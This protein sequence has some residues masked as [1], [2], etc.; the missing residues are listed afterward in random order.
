M[1]QEL[2]YNS[3]LTLILNGNMKGKVW[4][5]GNNDYDR[6]GSSDL[7]NVDFPS[8]DLNLNNIIQVSA[9]GMHFLLIRF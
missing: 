7:K 5:F 2:D 6:L 9:E 8:H 1:L 4:G 3:Y